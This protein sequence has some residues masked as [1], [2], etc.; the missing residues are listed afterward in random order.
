MAEIGFESDILNSVFKH[1]TLC[2]YNH[3]HVKKN[4]SQ[5]KIL[6][7]NTSTFWQWF[8]WMVQWYNYVLFHFYFDFPI[9]FPVTIYYC[10]NKL[11]LL[12]E[13]KI[14]S[15]NLFHPTL[16]SKVI[17]GRWSSVVLWRVPEMQTLQ[18]LVNLVNHSVDLPT[19]GPQKWLTPLSG[20]KDSL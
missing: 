1:D 4:R 2:V 13:R 6:E 9:I 11:Y 15:F 8:V 16:M 5:T 12:I 18:E 17:P 7:G 19:R 3:N 14:T 20:W 10:Y